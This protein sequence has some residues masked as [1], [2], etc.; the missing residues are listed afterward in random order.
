MT[1]LLSPKLPEARILSYGYK[2]EVYS[3]PGDGSSDRILPHA[4]TLVSDLYADRDLA[5]AIDRPI[6]FI[7][8]GLGG[9]IVKRAL[10]FSNTSTAK[11]VEHRRS[12]FT[13]T[14][15]II[16][17]GTPHFGMEPAVFRAKSKQSPNRALSQFA[18][19]LT[20]GSQ[21][22]QE[23]ND[24]F[25]PLTKRFSISCFWEQQ[26]TDLGD[27][28]AYVVD[29]SSAAPAWEDVERSGIAGNHSEICKF[30]HGN[31]GGLKLILSACRRGC[32]EA[33]N[34]V[35]NR[36][37]DDRARMK[38]ERK[39]EAQELIRHDSG[40]AEDMDPLHIHNEYLMVPRSAS[41]LFVGRKETAVMLRQKIIAS[42]SR[43]VQHQ[44]KIFVILGLGGSGKSEFC[45]KFVEDYRDR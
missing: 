18:D 42:S 31:H 37:I 45:L 25:A 39:Q 35:R 14:Y 4:L 24:Q 38:E 30:A 22:L 16:F 20:K 7:C 26:K 13:S 5:G 2:A 23:I 44:H 34:I 36:W 12:I 28:S 11:Q 9:I 10:A 17:L 6:I 41:T 43:K 29:E 33:P 27:F 1:D 8:H 15:T 40:L 32:R 3:S 19:A 21:L